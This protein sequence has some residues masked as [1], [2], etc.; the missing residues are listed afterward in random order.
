MNLV[1]LSHKVKR[2]VHE[3][4][5]S[6]PTFLFIAALF[7]GFNLIQQCPQEETPLFRKNIADLSAAR[8]NPRAY[9]RLKIILNVMFA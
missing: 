9:P 7:M 3:V 8:A 1:P 4:V 6:H 5:D 2:P